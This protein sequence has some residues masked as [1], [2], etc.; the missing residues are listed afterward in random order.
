MRRY[1]LIVLLRSRQKEARLVQGVLTRYGCIIK[2][3][4]GIHD[5]AA[6]KCGDTGLIILE[7][8]PETAKIKKFKAELDALS[9]V[10]TRLVGLSSR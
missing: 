6:E 5:A 7:L 8:C 4:L 9:G 10:T 2:I 1:L 3:R